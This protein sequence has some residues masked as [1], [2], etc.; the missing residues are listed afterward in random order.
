MGNSRI[1]QLFEKAETDDGWQEF[2]DLEEDL[3]FGNR[4]PDFE[5]LFNLE[6]DPGEHHNL[7]EEYEG[8][9]I[10]KELRAKCRE[11]SDDLN[12]QRE[13]YRKEFPVQLR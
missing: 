5:Q 10:L 4:E 7:I 2:E 13:A 6:K 9:E 8:T 3:D 11:K 1:A 12:R